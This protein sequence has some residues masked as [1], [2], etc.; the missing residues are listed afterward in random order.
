MKNV[1]HSYYSIFHFV[2]ESTVRARSAFWQCIL[3]SGVGVGKWPVAAGTG[4]R[5]G[6][7]EFAHEE[8]VGRLGGG[9]RAVPV[10]AIRATLP[11][12]VVQVEAAHLVR[13]AAHHEDARGR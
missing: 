13:A 1:I 12:P 8:H 4:S 6:R 11:V 5:G 2:Q 7:T 9:V 3:W 10:R